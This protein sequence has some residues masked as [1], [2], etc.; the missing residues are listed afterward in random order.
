MESMKFSPCHYVYVVTSM[1]VC[2]YTI[3]ACLPPPSTQVTAFVLWS[4]RS[5]SESR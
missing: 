4:G 2:T 3:F 1:F 5:E